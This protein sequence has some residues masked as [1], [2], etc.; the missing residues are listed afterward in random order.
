[1]LDEEFEKIKKR[2]NKHSKLIMK[3]CSLVIFFCVY[4]VCKYNIYLKN[5]IRSPHKPIRIC[6]CFIRSNILFPSKL[7]MNE[8]E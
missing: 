7:N 6:V 1:M 4:G 3:I 8:K 5:T 2:E